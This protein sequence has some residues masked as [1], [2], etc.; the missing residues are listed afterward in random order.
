M[1]PLAKPLSSEQQLVKI[2]QQIVFLT[3]SDIRISR[4]A[5]YTAAKIGINP[6]KVMQK[7]VDQELFPS[8]LI[9]C[10]RPRHYSAF[11]VHR[12]N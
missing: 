8:L 5:Q 12:T 10:L 2:A 3:I 6:L 11:P 7:T 1:R 9:G 4:K